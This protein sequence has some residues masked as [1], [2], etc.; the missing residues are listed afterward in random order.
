MADVQI[1]YSIIIPVFNSSDSVKEITSRLQAVFSHSVKDSY[2]II[3]IDDASHN[4][5]TWT[6]LQTLSSTNKEVRA[7]QLMR[8]FGKQS[9]MMCGFQEAKGKYIIT[10]DDDLQHFPEDIPSLIAQDE[11]DI[12]IGNFLKKNH[13]LYK[14]MLSSINSWFEEKLIGKPKNIR[15]TPF[16]LIKAEVI[17]QIKDIRSPYP[18][19]PALLFFATKDI[20]MVDVNHGKRL[21]NDSGFTIGKMYKTFSNLLFN[22]S[23]FLLQIIASAG[24]SISSLSFLGGLFYLIKKVTVG[25][26]VPGWTS[27]MIVTLFIGGLILFSIGVLGEYL[28]RIINAIENRPAYLVRKRTRDNE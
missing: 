5:E 23:S 22:N 19:V 10:M 25:I 14:R 15:N 16:K 26:A 18:Y 11:H 12:V 21:Y 3:F 8:N 6:V 20:V 13:G 24:M 9:A 28:I 2:E 4:K 1:K 7:V 27:L 17:D